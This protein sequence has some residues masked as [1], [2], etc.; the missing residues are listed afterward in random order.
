MKYDSY[1]RI[2]RLAELWRID[3][4]ARSAR[5]L[6]II[7][8]FDCYMDETGV[9]DSSEVVAVAG[10]LAPFSE[11]IRF[12]SEWNQAMH[13]YCVEDF[14]MTDFEGH[15]KEFRDNNYWTPDIRLR[16]IERA[17]EISRD[18]TTLGLG[19]AVSRKQYESALPSFVQSDL[20][21]PYFY[22]LY[23]CMSL[24]V[25]WQRDDRIRALKPINFLLDHKPG[26]FRFGS[27]M[28]SWEAFATELYQ[29]VKEGIDSE[30]EILGELTFG[31]RQ[32][33]PQLRAADLL[34]F[35]ARRWRE[36]QL[37]EISRPLRKSMQSLLRKQNLLIAF[38][39]KVR[40]ENFIRIITGHEAGEPE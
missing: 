23:G 33:Y 34:A 15:Y 25:N 21:H 4:R 30:G 2:R 9:H 31:K 35:E 10:Y 39:T 12:E 8:P 18:T 26:R 29:R 24:L 37:K 28:I 32:D 22:C 27:A 19:F 40:L 36:E 11:W 14:H 1:S 6:M 5:L 38:Q 16:L 20:R 13:L 7:Q 17:C 3:D